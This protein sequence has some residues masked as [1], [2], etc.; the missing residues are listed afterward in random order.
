MTNYKLKRELED[1]KSRREYLKKELVDI[2]K[3]EEKLLDFVNRCAIFNETII[4]YISQLLTYKHKEELYP[5]TYKRYNGS[6]MDIETIYVGI[7][8]CENII[9]FMR[10]KSDNIDEFFKQKLGYELFLKSTDI[11]EHDKKNK[12]GIINHYPYHDCKK[13]GK[14]IIFY[15]LLKKFGIKNTYP[16]TISLY[17][18]EDYSYVQDYISYLFDLQVQNN[19]RQLTDDEMFNALNDFLSKE[20]DKPKQKIK[21]KDNK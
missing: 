19:G 5:F 14:K 2:D 16:V 8:S 21:E 20:K 18:F 6:S 10:S 12:N 9:N 17:D 7:S 3:K 13:D 11:V 15:F 1:L 4:F